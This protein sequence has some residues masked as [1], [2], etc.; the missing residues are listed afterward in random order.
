MTELRRVKSL[1]VIRPGSNPDIDS[2][3]NTQ[4]REGVIQYVTEKYGKDN[5]ANIITFTSL[6]AKSAFKTMCTI[7]EVNF[8]QAT[9]I[10]GL[11][12][13][14]IEGEIPTMADLFDPSSDRYAE[15]ADFRLAVSGDEWKPIIEGAIGIEGRYKSTGVHPCGLIISDESLNEIIPLQVRQE[16]N[17]VI[18]QWTY[19]ELEDMGLIKFDFLGL[20]TVD[21]IQHTVEYIIKNGKTPPNMVDII[22]GEMDDKKT[23]EALSRG[24]SVGIFQLGSDI[25]RD[26]L[27]TMKPTEFS[28]IVAATALMRPGPM[29]MNSH[30]RY[31]QRKNGFEPITVLH[32]DFKGSPL[33]EIL[34]KTYGVVIYQEQVLQIANRIAGMTLQEGDDL[35]KAMGKKIIPKMAAIQPK[36]IAGGIA[37]GYSREAMTRIWDTCA[38]FAKYGFNKCAHGETVILGE[39]GQKWRLRDLH[40]RWVNGEKD[41]KL[42]SMWEDGEIKPH[43]VKNIVYTGK[44]PTYEVITKAG[45]KIRITKEHRLLTTSG[46]GTIED[47]G[48]AVGIELM[49]DE[50][51][52]GFGITPEDRLRRKNGFS[53]YNKSELGRKKA[54]E[55][56][57]KTQSNIT[58]E[59]RC[60]WQ[61]EIQE[62]NPDRT[63]N[64]LNTGRERLRE[65]YNDEEWVFNL[66]NNAKRLFKERNNNGYRGFGKLT[67]ISDGRI[68]DSMIEAVVA[69]YMI[70]RGIEFE[71]HKEVTSPINSSPRLSDFYS[72]GI[73][74]EI[75]GLRR[76]KD[77]FKENKYGDVPFVYMTPYDYMDKID[78]AL[79]LNHV[80]NG[81]EIVSIS[82]PSAQGHKVYDIEMELDG[83]SNFIADGIISHN[84]HSVA[85]GMAAYQAAF[86]KTNYPV[87]FMAA[88]VSQNV[89]V[90][91]K[92]LAFLK[93]ANK[94]GITIGS[95]DINLSDVKVA[96]D[97]TGSSS[98][99]VL[100][101]LSGINS[102]SIENAEIII[103][104]R[105]RNG[106]Y[107]SVQDLINRCVPLG[108]NKKNIY[109]NLAFAGAFDTFGN[110]RQS[111]VVNLPAMMGE[112]K[113]KSSLGESLFD[114]ME[115]EETTIKFDEPE[116]PFVEKL[117]KEAEVIGLYLTD[118]PLSRVGNSLTA[119]GIQSVS[120]LLASYNK[121]SVRIAGSLTDIE[122][123]IRKTGGK[124]ISVT[125]DDGTGYINAIV[126]K[127]IVKGIDKFESQKRLE[128]FY[129][130][131]E[132]KIND[133][134]VGSA[135]SNFDICEPLEKNNVYIFTVNYSP[136]YGNG[137]YSARITSIEKL[138]LTDEGKLPIRVRVNKDEKLSPKGTPTK[139]GNAIMQLNK[140]QKGDYPVHWGF[141]DEEAQQVVQDDSIYYLKLAEAINSFTPTVTTVKKQDDNLFAKGT[142]VA[143]DNKAAKKK[144]KVRELPART[145]DLIKYR[146]ATEE[147][148]ARNVVYKNTIPITLNKSNKVAETLNEFFAIE[149]IDWGVF[150]PEDMND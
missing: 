42:L 24:D 76:G 82:G 131:G 130:Y 50:T 38:E 147:E 140:T 23:Y 132:T 20:D 22:H 141:V 51:E 109:E 121:G 45:R 29:G 148:I 89:G 61:S 35:R 86:L 17:R 48:L 118:H 74:F 146:K 40:K 115:V 102:V 83:P 128:N 112:A 78:E 58:H 72:N 133:D 92:I 137:R 101:G 27:K 75:D 18:T 14:P 65:L 129:E 73:Y 63:D 126:G 6:A 60:K 5:V 103:D 13:G 68:C 49:V 84:S 106:A 139:L 67:Q 123:K 3:F 120:T 21:L 77:W 32:E 127:E 145:N 90:K 12:P 111:I 85:Y 105:N 44:K 100:Y 28:D 87:E 34:G 94:M 30:T 135:T 41:I 110:S 47:G 1:R 52:R 138:V 26:F 97:Y 71:L 37:N 16:D 124:S 104:E 43:R 95:T 80:H 98:H 117:Q 113:N 119:S 134:V 4:K 64:W 116:Y 53:A 93:E 46:Y 150:N 59:Q 36:F 125:I 108:V 2:D 55:T 62:N 33:E 143:S 122:T 31:A 8:Q 107:T 15:G 79:T 149:R 91:E 66:K 136:A 69:E 96:P 114:L 11:I 70:S 81:D 57:S 7:Y 9:K 54:S 25:V 142:N 99:Q 88:L 56:M 144:V 10:A 39:H 19:P